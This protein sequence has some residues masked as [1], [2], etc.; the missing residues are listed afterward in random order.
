MGVGDG[1]VSDGRLVMVL[2]AGMVDD[3]DVMVD[4]EMDAEPEKVD[5]IGEPGVDAELVDKDAELVELPVAPELP[6]PVGLPTTLESGR[7]GFCPGNVTLVSGI[8]S[9]AHSSIITNSRQ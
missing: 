4:C 7:F 6:P 8:P 2:W 5:I 1:M 3:I 9:S